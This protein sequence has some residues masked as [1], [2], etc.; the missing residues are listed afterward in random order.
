M[1]GVV[2]MPVA[3][4]LFASLAAIHGAIVTEKRGHIWDAS[5]QAFDVLRALGL[6]VPS[7]A[8]FVSDY[9]TT[10]GLVIARGTAP[11]GSGAALLSIGVHECR[12]VMQFRASPAAFPMRYLGFVTGERAAAREPRAAYEAE[13]LADQAA[14]E[15]ALTG[16]VDMRAHVGALVYG[17][18]LNADD[19]TLAT[20]LFAQSSEAIHHG[21]IPPGPA[22][23][24]IALVATACP[25]ALNPRAYELIRANCPDALVLS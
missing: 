18:D 20:G 1:S 11:V 24:A 19:V 10:I 25:E 21:L 15:W 7:G 16:V 9:W 5:R 12:H 2:E 14:L 23:T 6:R 13:A 3:E 8:E 17:Y 22:R 4:R